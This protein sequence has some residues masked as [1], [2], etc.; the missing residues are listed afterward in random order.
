MKSL[1]CALLILSIL[2]LTSC[3]VNT[4]SRTYDVAFMERYEDT[5]SGSSHDFSS[6]MTA[7]PYDQMITKSHD[8]HEF[9]EHFGIEVKGRYV[10]NVIADRM[11][12]ECLRTNC[13]GIRYSIHKIKQG[14]LLYIFYSDREEG[15]ARNWFYVQKDQ[16]YSDFSSI[17]IGSSI[18]EVERIDPAAQLSENVF[19]RIY[20]Y[21]NN[22]GNWSL[23]S[24]HY[25]ND[26]VLAI[27]YEY[28]DDDFV[29]YN[30]EYFDDYIW[31]TDGST[32]RVTEWDVSLLPGDWIA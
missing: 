7:L 12:I 5:D 19:R 18:K 15:W 6:A 22:K 32:G 11:G 30:I 23:Y 2:G 14:G 1:F 21:N 24:Q 8:I 16:C 28:Q 25:L 9:L 29:V 3:S 17:Q 27:Y 13:S 26:G 10:Q 20:R 4:F 31:R